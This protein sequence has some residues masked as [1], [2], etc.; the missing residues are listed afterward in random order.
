MINVILNPLRCL[1]VQK[2]PSPFAQQGEEQKKGS[3]PKGSY[4]YEP[5]SFHCLIVLSD[6][7][8][9]APAMKLS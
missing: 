1:P 7:P 8:L 9:I 3:Y 2:S 6:Q 5:R 4:E